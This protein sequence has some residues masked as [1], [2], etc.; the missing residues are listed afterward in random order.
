MVIDDQL[1][2]GHARALI[3]VPN[4]IEKAQEIL[5]KNLSVRQVEKITSEFKKTKK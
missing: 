2:M 3:G 4:A 1:T 5:S